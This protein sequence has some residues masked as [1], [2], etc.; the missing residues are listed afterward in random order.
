MCRK[1]YF[2]GVKANEIEIEEG[3]ELCVLINMLL[4]RVNLTVDMIS[5]ERSIWYSGKGWTGLKKN[6]TFKNIL[7]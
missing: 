7:K 2:H 5:Y 4:F 1:A 3:S 6:L